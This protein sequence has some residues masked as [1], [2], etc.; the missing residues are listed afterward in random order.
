MI[1]FLGAASLY[2]VLFYLASFCRSRPVDVDDDDDD[3]DKGDDEEDAFNQDLI[4]FNRDSIDD[5]QARYDGNNGNGN[6]EIYDSDNNAKYLPGEKSSQV[7]VEGLSRRPRQS[8]SSTHFPAP[9]PDQF[10]SMVESGK[11]VIRNREPIQNLKRVID[12]LPGGVLPAA[13]EIWTAESLKVVNDDVLLFLK[14]IA[15]GQSHHED[16][17]DPCETQR[18]E[19]AKAFHGGMRLWKDHL[20]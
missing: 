18:Q 16:I 9:S 8:V 19:I 5:N 1:L 14:E 4:V 17:E 6:V 12:S 20:L 2:A 10:W 13:M 15:V 7:R 11:H 3:D